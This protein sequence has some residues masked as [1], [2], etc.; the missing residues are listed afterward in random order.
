[1]DHT[2]KDAATPSLSAKPRRRWLGTLIALIGLAL[3]GGVAWY[4]THRPAAAPSGAMAGGPGGPGG[5]GGGP[6]GA[7]GRRGAGATTVGV[8]TAAQAELPVL[9]EA[10]GTVTPAATVTVRPQVSGVLTKVAFK[11]GQVVKKGELLATIDARPFE[12]ALL[13]ASGQRLRDEAQLDAARVTLKRY[14]T[15]LSQ[16]SIARQD[17]DTQAA[18]V[19]QLEGTAMTDKAAEGTARLNLAYTRITAPVGGRI[20]LRTVDEG[21]LVSSGDA[22]GIAVIT[23]TE[24]IDIAFSIPQDR[25]P[26]I[27]AR[28]ASGAQLPVAAYDRT[29][30]TKLESG[31]FSTF[32]NLVDTTTGTV[33]AKA[34]FQNAGGALFPNQ[35]VNVRLLLD[36][37][38]G[39]VVVPITALRNGR[40]GD[41][42]YV[43]Q[44]DRTVQQRTVT[45]GQATV[46]KVS[47][48]AGLEA[49]E[50]V[51]TEGADRL[52]DGARV[53]L[54]ADRAASGAQ[55]ASGP[56]GAF[57]PGRRASG[58]RG[59]RG[60]RAAADGA[61][62]PAGFA[63]GASGAWGERRRQRREQAEQQ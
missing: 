34:R 60:P 11:E 63:S 27:Q 2:P 33:R 35:F 50:Q 61:S 45:R 55:G 30:T 22:T 31:A 24:P 21:N 52:K 43:L 17:V 4:L 36:T 51:I 9:I 5:P 1:M 41:Y 39:A 29:R 38:K 25:L 49:G 15:L 44:P 40:D 28:V 53:T 6:G 19:K 20:G 26:A 54:S 37:V 18:L 56:A 32:D 59:E 3:L 23:Q 47:I 8:A 13:Q 46:D 42:V 58:P 62:A 48:T 16:D 57:P 14:Q 12:M 10:L 7:A